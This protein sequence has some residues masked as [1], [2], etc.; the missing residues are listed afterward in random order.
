[1][2]EENKTE[3]THSNLDLSVVVLSLQELENIKRIAYLKGVTKYTI[4]ADYVPNGNVI[5]DEY[6]EELERLLSNEDNGP[7]L[8]L[9]SKH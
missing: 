6:Q 7:Q 4:W 9:A 2:S 8:L 1:M 5:C 3:N